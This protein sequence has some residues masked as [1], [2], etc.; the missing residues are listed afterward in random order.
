MLQETSATQQLVN[1]SVTLSTLHQNIK[2]DILLYVNTADTNMVRFLEIDREL[3]EQQVDKILSFSNSEKQRTLIE[4]YE[5]LRTQITQD[6]DQLIQ[7]MNEGATN[8][9]TTLAIWQHKRLYMD[10][11]LKDILNYNISKLDRSNALI[12]DSIRRVL[13]TGVIITLTS[14]LSIVL[15]AIF[16]ERMVTRPIK[17]LSHYALHTAKGNF[18]PNKISNPGGDEIGKLGYALN[19]MTY[20]LQSYYNHLQQEVIDKTR[21]LRFKER[22]ER[23][24]DD[25][26][27][28]ASHELKTPITSQRA[29]LQLMKR[30]MEKDQQ[31]QYLPYIQKIEQQTDKLVRLI[32][33]LLDVSKITAG[34]LVIHKENFDFTKM[35]KDS[36]EEVNHTYK[37]HQIEYK[38]NGPVKINADK[39]RINQVITNLLINA[40]K[41]SPQADRIDVLYG[42]VGN[43]LEVR[44]RDYGIGI[45]DK[46]QGK[47]FQR[48]YRVSGFNEK[49][50][51]GMGIGLNIS[52][53][54]IKMHGGKIRVKSKVGQGSEFIFTLP[55]QN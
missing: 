36:V 20:K 53:E 2:S 14:L 41:Y 12:E 9:R 35:L 11:M 21:R 51:S 1:S 54:I 31:T 26:I 50:F 52:S 38:L 49:T 23:Q 25:F 34:R 16:L 46:H 3:A 44:I 33:D 22:L 19:T 5:K 13:A 7:L 8:L 45:E 55:L 43:N 18:S 42:V 24:K 39:Y 40:V 4:R 17:Q 28:M 47:I 10:A 48:F 6:E 15:L 29:F 27:A 32:S 30:G 37:T